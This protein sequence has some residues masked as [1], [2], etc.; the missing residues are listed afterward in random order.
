[1]VEVQQPTQPFRLQDRP[2]P[3]I[4][5]SVGKRYHVRDPLMI[6][7]GV[8]VR[9]VFPNHMPRP[10]AKVIGLTGM[11]LDSVTIGNFCSLILKTI[12]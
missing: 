11:N 4:Q 8:I 10:S 2:F 9:Q 12:V 7:F 3:C 1:M 6:S 5:P